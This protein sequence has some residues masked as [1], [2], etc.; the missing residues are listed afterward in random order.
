ME[1]TMLI[2][3]LEGQEL[4]KLKTLSQKKSIR[5]KLIAPADYGQRV[6]AFCGVAKRLETLPEVSGVGPML[7]FAHVAERQLDAFITELRTARV[8]LNA[9]KAILTPTNAGWDAGKLYAELT[10]ERN[11]MGG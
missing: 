10:K 9:I 1:A 7:V 11:E 2:Y 6:G 4:K 3:G 8:G 5:P